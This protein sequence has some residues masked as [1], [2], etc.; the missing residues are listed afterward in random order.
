MLRATLAAVLLLSCGPTYQM[1]PSSAFKRYEESGGL[2][3]ITATGVR[4]KVRE[5]DNYPIADLAFWQDAMERHLLARGYALKSMERFTTTSGHSAATLDFVLPYGSEDWVLS[6]TI[7]VVG[8]RIVL[9][10][11]AG[12]YELFV[13]V[14]AELRASLRSFDP[15]T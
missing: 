15:G 3:L 7:L 6:E 11:A 4:V 13:P 2:K 8:D 1:Q 10:E 12:P 14:E 9:V 5:V